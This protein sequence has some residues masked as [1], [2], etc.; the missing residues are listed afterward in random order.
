MLNIVEYKI[1]DVVKIEQI[2]SLQVL[3]QQIRLYHNRNIVLSR[4]VHESSTCSIYTQQN[5]NITIGNYLVNLN[6]V[7]S[8]HQIVK[9]VAKSYRK[10]RTNSLGKL[11]T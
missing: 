10:S 3:S 9:S 5:S 2:I 4:T 8:L 6:R 11:I 1:A 7:P